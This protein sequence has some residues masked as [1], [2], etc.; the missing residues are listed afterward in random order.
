MFAEKKYFR[1]SKQAQANDAANKKTESKIEIIWGRLTYTKLIAVITLLLSFA[2]YGYDYHFLNHFG[3]EPSKVN[4]T[5]TEF[6]VRGDR[7]IIALAEAIMNFNKVVFTVKFFKDAV[8]QIGLNTFLITLGL[9]VAFLVIHYFS[10]NE[11]IIK[12]ACRTSIRHYS[13]ALQWVNGTRRRR[14]GVFV[15]F[16]PIINAV[17]F[18]C[19]AYIFVIIIWLAGSIFFL[20]LSLVPLSPA[21]AARAHAEKYVIAPV[22]CATPAHS[23][24]TTPGALC[25]RVTRQGCEVAK[26]RMIDVAGS[27]IWLLHKKPWKVFSVPLDGNNLEYVSQPEYDQQFPQ[28]GSVP[29]GAPCS[30]S[31]PSTAVTVTPAA[32]AASSASLTA[33]PSA[34]PTSAPAPP[35]QRTIRVPQKVRVKPKVIDQRQAGSGPCSCSSGDAHGV[36]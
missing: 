19:V 2:S 1:K 18:L 25:V 14:Y 4:R 27:R 13:T 10:K 34:V 23:A 30:P 6:L 12:I 3:I 5:P 33:N 32:G 21:R 35:L 7:P 16:L 31:L 36:R 22:S 29:A 28:A 15:I 11:T 24:S 26:G 8:L 20:A 17:M 9:C